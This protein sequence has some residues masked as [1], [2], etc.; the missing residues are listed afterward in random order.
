MKFS[1]L[2]TAATVLLLA[3]NVHALTKWCNFGTP[4]NGECEKIPSGYHT[5]SVSS[6]RKLNSVFAASKRLTTAG[7]YSAMTKKWESV[8]TRRRLADSLMTRRARRFVR[9]SGAIQSWGLCGVRSEVEGRGTGMR[10]VRVEI[11]GLPGCIKS[12]NI[13]QDWNIG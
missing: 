9:I 3:S 11:S 13:Y 5:F 7:C 6:V 4:G 10:G 1:L 8:R 12:L 2:T